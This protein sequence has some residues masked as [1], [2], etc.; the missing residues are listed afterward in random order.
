MDPL[1][2]STIFDSH[3]FDAS[4]YWVSAALRLLIIEATTPGLDTLDPYRGVLL[5][6]GLALEVC[7]TMKLV[8]AKGTDLDSGFAVFSV[9]GNVSVDLSDSEELK[10]SSMDSVW[11]S[12][13]A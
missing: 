4:I 3:N 6:A 10:N 13:F 12:K 2:I 11:H 5:E 7:L 1:Q 9:F 8:L